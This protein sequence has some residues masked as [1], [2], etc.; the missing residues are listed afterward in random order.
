MKVLP[1]PESYFDINDDLRVEWVRGDALV[2][3]VCTP[4]RQ[5]V[6]WRLNSKCEQHGI[7]DVAALPEKLRWL[8]A[9]AEGVERG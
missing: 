2:E 1:S 8:L 5:Y 3:L 9:Q 6:W 4:E 7:A